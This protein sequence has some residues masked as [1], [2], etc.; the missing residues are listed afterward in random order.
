MRVESANESGN[1]K[2]CRRIPQ[3]VCGFRILFITELACEQ[4][5]ARAGTLI[6]SN[7]EIKGNDHCQRCLR[8]NLKKFVY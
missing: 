7:A 6:Y 8:T 1:R 3:T 2:T 5:K 4:L